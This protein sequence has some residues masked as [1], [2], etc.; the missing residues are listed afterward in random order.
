MAGDRIVIKEIYIRNFRSI[1]KE[2]IFATGFNVFVGNNDVG[3]SNVLKALNLFF[4]NKTD[5]DTDFQFASDFTILP[6]RSH[7]KKE[8]VIQIKV[9]IPD[10]FQNGGEYTWTRTWRN[11]DTPSETIVDQDGKEPGP[12]S[13]IPLT[14]KRI[15]F[16]YVP[17]VR[18]P[19]YYK[20][21]LGDLYGAVASS[22]ENPLITSASSFSA[23]LKKYT[24]AL[25]KQ[26]SER[27]QL[28]SELAIPND[29][30]DIFQA[31]IF[32]TNDSKSDIHVPLTFR[33][34][35]IQAMHV[36]IVLKYIADE[37]QKSR[38][39]G[40]MR[41]YTIWGFEE[42]ENGLEFSNSFKMA[43]ELEEYA[44]DIQIFLTTHSP[45]FY[46]KKDTNISATVFYVSKPIGSSNTRIEEETDSSRIA[47]SM[48]LMQAVAPLI[49]EKENELRNAQLELKAATEAIAEARAKILLIT[50]GA[51]D[52]KHLKAAYNSL[53]R[54]PKH[55]HV[56]E[57]LDIEFLEYEPPSLEMGGAALTKACEEHAK[58][59]QP[60]TM[61]FIADR[62]DD[63]ALRKLG[64]ANNGTH[65]SWGNNVFSFVLPIPR[66]R[67]IT[68]GISIEHLYSDDEIK[69]ELLCEDGVY[70]RLYLGNEFD[71]RGIAIGIKRFCSTKNKCG[72]GKICV[73]DDAVTGT[74]EHEGGI[75][76]ALSKMDFAKSVYGVNEGFANMD[77]SGFVPV[78]AVIKHIS[79]Q[80]TR[81]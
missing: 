80:A 66:H 17:A 14:L 10:A 57:G 20:K 5:F 16:K 24:Q 73:I 47:N 48:G 78:F 41:I 60:R 46:L 11:E 25:S 64:G 81:K 26:V 79:M 59:Q 12:R 74:E 2:T 70:R 54:D 9:S 23:E 61:I 35:G 75:N 65:K 6:K 71:R 19:D 51:S 32:D 15:Q 22:L 43:D 52:W 29:L 77:F 3:K 33:G 45:A 53:S 42:P 55:A 27:L 8:I 38:K 72:E 68:P 58:I 31:L 40:S 67:E 39:Q 76:Y 63:T 36:P 56:F 62:D 1:R 37:V 13:R 69:T 7:D 50:E 34:D 44:K 49:A 18:S 30:N 28:S 21:L 4:N